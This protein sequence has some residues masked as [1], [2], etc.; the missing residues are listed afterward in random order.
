MKHSVPHDLDLDQARAVTDKALEA[1]TAKF[2]EYNP[3]VK[4]LSDTQA[5]VE[6]KAKGVKV[7]GEFTLADDR[8]DVDMQVPMLLKVFQKKAIDVV[9]REIR[10]WIEK[11]KNGEL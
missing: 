8:I 10:K 9:E 7:K 6:F 11:A 3:N 2:A 1:Y 4:W 5:E